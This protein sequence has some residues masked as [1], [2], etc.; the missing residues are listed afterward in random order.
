MTFTC[1]NCSRTYGFGALGIPSA[2]DARA[3]VRCGCGRWLE[4]STVW[5]YDKEP[6]PP[7]VPRSWWRSLFS[8]GQDDLAAEYTHSTAKLVLAACAKV[9]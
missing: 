5:V 7:P 2:P 8:L 9:R 6:T 1:P 3:T 4:V